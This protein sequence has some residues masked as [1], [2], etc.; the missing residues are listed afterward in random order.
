MPDLSAREQRIY[1]KTM[2]VIGRVMKRN[3]YLALAWP[4]LKGPISEG[5]ADF[6]D[7]LDT[8]DDE[9][10]EAVE[11]VAQSQGDAPPADAIPALRAAVEQMLAE[12]PEKPKKRKRG[13]GRRKRAD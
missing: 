1:D 3:A 13:G 5:V 4:F 12:L 8:S 6:V 9:V 2:R 11:R 10:G 7:R